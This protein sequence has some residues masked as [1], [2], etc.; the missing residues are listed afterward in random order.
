M[1]KNLLLLAACLLTAAPALSAT[2]LFTNPAET[3]TR[4]GVTCTNGTLTGA[5]GE[6]YSRQPI[7][8]VSHFRKA[9]AATAAVAITID[10]STACKVSAPTRLL[11]FEST[12]ELGLMATPG[13]ITGNWHGAPWGETIPY[14]KLATHPAAFCREIRAYSPAQLRLIIDEQ[15]SEYSEEEFAYIQKILTLKT[16]NNA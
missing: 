1:K 7:Y 13:G 15:K 8:N 11:T 12:H 4:A 5:H 2:A 3:K 14:G 9:N 10:L 6:L 16:Q